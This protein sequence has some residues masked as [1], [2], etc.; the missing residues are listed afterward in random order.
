MA[1]RDHTGR[2]VV[3]VGGVGLAAWWLLSRGGGMGFRAPGSG[4]DGKNVTNQKA[5]PERVVVW[6]RAN[7]LEI[8]G[9]VADLQTVVAKS[10][11]AGTAEVHATGDAITH[12]VSDVLRALDAAKVKLETPPDLAHYLPKPK[13]LS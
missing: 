10:R 13:V 12:V 1:T 4:T 9:V 2:D 11:E 5:R 3:L 6:I 8:D 7:R